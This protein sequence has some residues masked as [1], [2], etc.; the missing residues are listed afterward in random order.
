MKKKSKITVGTQLV[1]TLGLMMLSL[2]IVGA[3]GYLMRNNSVET[4]TELYENYGETQGELAMGF[5]Q[6][7]N[8][9]VQLRNIL[10]MYVGDDVNIEA[11]KSKIEEAKSTVNDYMTEVKGDLKDS[12]TKALYENVKNNI[13]T[14]FNDAEKCL[15]YFNSGKIQDARNYLV[16]NGVKSA[17][18]A[19]ENI[20]KLIKEIDKYAQKKQDYV[21]KQNKTGDYFVAV[22]MLLALLNACVAF[23][24]IKTTI[25]NPIVELA[26][27][28]KKVSAGDVDVSITPS[29]IDNE[30]GALVDGFQM[31]TDN[32]KKQ[33]EVLKQISDGNLTVSYQPAS[34]NDIVGNAILRL[35]EDN[36]TAF[37]KIRNAAGQIGN[38]SEQIAS[39]SQTLAQGSSEQASAIQQI[40]ASVTDIANKTKDNAKKASEVNDI[41]IRAKSDA[42]EGNRCMRE[43][44]VAMK[45]INESSENIQ[46]IIKVIDDIAFNTNILALN[47]TVE[48]ARAGEQGKGFAVVAEE[49]RNLAGR[50]A[51]ASRQTAELIEDSIVKVKHGSALASDTEKALEVIS[52]MIEKIT[53]LSANISSA[54]NEQAAATSQIDDALTQVSQVVQTNSATSE[55]CASASEELSGQAR[56]LENTLGRFKIKGEKDISLE[57]GNMSKNIKQMNYIPDRGMSDNYN[58][59]IRLENSY[60]TK[61]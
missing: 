57:Y 55:E 48:A 3:C 52:N 54:S 43:M 47:A 8:V 51:E 2:F 38:G 32:L 45:E 49:V 41:V 24:F 17:D 23:W 28:A 39:A 12:A 33:A 6:F 10:Y 16:D 14:Y 53:D 61:Y 5:A 7:Q 37:S 15:E 35:I 9:K 36:N 27:V 30:V 34:E 29:K 11:S 4:E 19:E 46:K 1:M 20:K 40:S 44:I 22:I 56:G 21:T 58:N 13:D 60:D 25:R 59:D 42:D 26:G 31:M 18:K 50:S